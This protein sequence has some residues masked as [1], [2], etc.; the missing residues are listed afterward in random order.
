MNK[1]EKV[2]IN[3]LDKEFKNNYS[4]EELKEM[5]FYADESTENFYAWI[6]E[7]EGTKY[8]WIYLYKQKK[9]NKSFYKR[10]R[11]SWILL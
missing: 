9:I 3:A 6:F 8:K 11:D 5:E 2:A 7:H 4:E 1:N 10:G